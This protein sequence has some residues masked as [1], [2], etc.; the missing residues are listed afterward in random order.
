[1]SEMHPDLFGGETKIPERAVHQ[2]EKML[3]VWRRVA[4]YRRANE[5]ENSCKTCEFHVI[6]GGVANTYHKC[7]KLGVTG[8]SAS[9]IRTGHTCDNWKA[10][11]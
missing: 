1:M 10:G 7:R 3:D 11:A 4:H 5:G 8:S 2:K 6:P 9:D